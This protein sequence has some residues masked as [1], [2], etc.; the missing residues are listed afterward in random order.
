MPHK[1]ATGP[2]TGTQRRADKTAADVEISG[3]A[4]RTRPVGNVGDEKR[5]TIHSVITTDAC[6]PPLL[7]ASH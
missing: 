5:H 7:S 4:K 6:P 2:P 1:P 3:G